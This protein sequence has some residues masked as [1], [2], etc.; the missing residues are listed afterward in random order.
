MTFGIVFRSYILFHVGDKENM[1]LAPHFG[2]LFF[3]N[4]PKIFS[5]QKS[6][7]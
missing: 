2:K 7:K 5:F 1:C 6:Q 3:K 4:D